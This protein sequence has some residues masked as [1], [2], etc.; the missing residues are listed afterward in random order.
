MKFVV[1]LKT[2][3]VSHRCRH[4]CNFLRLFQQKVCTYGH[5]YC[6]CTY[7]QFK[8][9]LVENVMKSTLFQFSSCLGVFVFMLRARGRDALYRSHDGEVTLRG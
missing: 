6:I 7:S 8:T 2:S 4:Q 9:E 1:K 3:A 5:V